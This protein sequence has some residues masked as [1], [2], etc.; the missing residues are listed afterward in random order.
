[1]N[2]LMENYASLDKNKNYYIVCAGGYRSMIACSILASKGFVNLTN[3]NG[4]MARVKETAKDL[5]TH[6]EHVL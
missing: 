3:V 6:P 2:T 5:V 1:L 4:G